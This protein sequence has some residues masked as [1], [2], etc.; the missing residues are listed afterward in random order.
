MSSKKC[1][2][3][4]DILGFSSYICSDANLAQESAMDM[5]ST[6]NFIFKNRVSDHRLH[7]WHSY[8]PSLQPHAQRTDID[9]FE[10][11]LPMSDSIFI[12]GNDANIFIDQVSSFMCS[13]FNYVSNAYLNPIDN[14]APERVI[15]KQFKIDESDGLIVDEV[16]V[17]WYP[18]I[19]RG[20]ISYNDA[21][22]LQMTSLMRNENNMSDREKK[23]ASDY[24]VKTGLR[25][26][27]ALYRKAKEQGLKVTHKSVKSCL[28]CSYKFICT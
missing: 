12:I 6:I 14:N 28:V 26:E 25:G 3:F 5:L 22:I 9:S 24:N 13:C 19:F 20:G 17:Q 2:A 23:I 21:V 7:P 18:H 4:L 27:N 15:A 11:F 10:C 1:V 8:C 16:E